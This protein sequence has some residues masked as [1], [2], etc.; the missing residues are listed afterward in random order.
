MV[1]HMVFWNLKENAAGGTKEQNAQIIKNSLESLLGKIEGLRFIQV[2]RN[3]T[4][5]SEHAWDLGAYMEFDDIRALK[6]YQTHP[7]HLEA[8]KLTSEMKCAQALCD[9][10]CE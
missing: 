6:F 10:E 5:E 8:K 4:T 2:D 7:L 1:R 3:I 9:F